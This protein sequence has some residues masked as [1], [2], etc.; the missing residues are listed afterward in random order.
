LAGTGFSHISAARATRTLEHA[1]DAR[2]YAKTARTSRADLIPLAHKR[3]HRYILCRYNWQRYLLA[4]TIHRAR[5]PC[6]AEPMLKLALEGPSCSGKSSLAHSLSIALQDVTIA[7]DY[8]HLLSREIMPG[9]PAASLEDELQ[10]LT[11]LLSVDRQRMRCFVRSNPKLLILDR[12]VHTLLAHRYALT[13]LQ[14]YDVF[15]ASVQLAK[16]NM[17]VA[18]PDLILYLDVPQTVLE[19]RYRSRSTRTVFM[20]ESYNCAFREYFLPTLKAGEGELV[21]IDAVIPSPELLKHVMSYVAP[22]M[23][24]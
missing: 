1:V 14:I 15:K 7:M 13:K 5:F 6:G 4:A 9:V 3:T 18:W 11:F 2:A 22:R 19:T 24:D 12:S 20:E 17:N 16:A 23:R 21:A 10:D 8:A